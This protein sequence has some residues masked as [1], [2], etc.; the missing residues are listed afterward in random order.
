MTRSTYS[1]CFV[2]TERELAILNDRFVLTI[3]LKAKYLIDGFLLVQD[4]YYKEHTNQNEY[5]QNYS[6]HV[7]NNTDWTKN[8][9]CPGGPFM[10]ISM[11]GPQSGWVFDQFED[12]MV[13]RYGTERPCNLVGRY[14]TIFAD[15]SAI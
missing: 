5:F 7:G 14:V 8:P 3:D 10:T 1:S 13:W 12:G 9:S 6:M 4:L 15:Y 2:T 11:D